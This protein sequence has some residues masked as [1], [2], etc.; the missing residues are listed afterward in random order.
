MRPWLSIIIPV[1]NVEKYI[2]QCLDSI[3]LQQMQVEG[4]IEVIVIDDGATDQSGEIAREY[5]KYTSDI[6]HIQVIHKKNAGVAAARN[7]GIE[8]ATGEW[9][10]FVDADDYLEPDCLQVMYKR[11]RQSENCDVILFDAFQNEK[12]KQAVWEHFGEAC[13]WNTRDEIFRLQRAVLYY[14]MPEISTK[15]P[16]AAP[17]DKVY[18]SEFIL[19]KGLCFQEKLRVLDD[20][21]F[22]MEAFGEAAHI[23]YYKDKIYHYR[24]VSNSITHQYKP[25]RVEQDR[26]VWEYISQYIRVKRHQWTEEELR[27]FEQA[28][29]C[30]IIKSFSI[31]CSLQFFA[32]QNKNPLGKK[33]DFVKRIWQQEPF[34][35]AFQKVKIK[36]AEWKLRCMIVCAR[37]RWGYGAWLL[38]QAQTFLVKLR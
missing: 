1:Y 27:S 23:A 29:Y 24:Y 4:C 9:L 2:R 32:G 22:N 18:R 11:I 38:Y 17:W 16:L 5:E 30:R 37:L 28:F 7:T 21:I 15:Q 6:M 31:C 10:Y 20:M 8:H 34:C 26:L 19:N 14:K 12:N 35:K 13:D 25:N 33:V 36:N 3:V